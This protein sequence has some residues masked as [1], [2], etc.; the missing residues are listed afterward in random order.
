MGRI[1]AARNVHTTVLLLFC[2]IASIHVIHAAPAT[3]LTFGAYDPVFTPFFSNGSVNLAVI[4]AYAKYT[5]EN[6]TD[7]IILGGST[8]EWPSMTSVERINVLTAW[9]TAVDALPPSSLPLGRKPK[10]MFHAGDIAVERAVALAQAADTVA[11]SIL[12]VAPCIMKP[13]SLDMLVRVIGIIAAAAPNC[14]AYYYHYPSLYTVDFPMATFLEQVHRTNAIPT[15]AGVKYIDGNL[16][17][18]A[19]AT[20][21]A[22]GKYAMI[23]TKILSGLSIGKGTRGGIVYTPVA[24]YLNAVMRDVTAGNSTAANTTEARLELLTHVL[25]AKPGGKE[26]V[27]ASAKIFADID[28]GPPR[29]PLAD[30]TRAEYDAMVSNLHMNGFLP[31]SV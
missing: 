22:D 6:G 26:A 31:P 14:P 20:E 5:A 2:K 10:I 23:T 28:L 25:S 16:T 11:D 8:G 15:L 1:M 27:R 4:P 24:P 18:L 9:R 21:V 12:I 19:A 17:D 29:L 3:T 7:T 30:V 13:D